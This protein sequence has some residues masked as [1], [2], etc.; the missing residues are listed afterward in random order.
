MTLI[1]CGDSH[2]HHVA[3]ATALIKAMETK[4]VK[5]IVVGDIVEPSPPTIELELLC[6]EPLPMPVI[7]DKRFEP[8]KGWKTKKELF[9]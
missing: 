1:I 6:R 2:L 3:E 7:E 4:G 8:R 5:V 9:R